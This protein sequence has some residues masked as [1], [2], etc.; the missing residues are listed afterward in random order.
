MDRKGH[1]LAP[2]HRFADVDEDRLDLGVYRE[3]GAVPQLARVSLLHGAEPHSLDVVLLIR[4]GCRDVLLLF[5][6][7][8]AD[9]ELHVL[10]ESREVV[11]PLSDTQEPQRRH[12]H[13]AGLPYRV[14]GA[15]SLAR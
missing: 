9:V 1:L 2:S 10:D 5:L 15:A 11:E 14:R 4:F 6:E 7:A 8:M 13:E 3:D 12:L